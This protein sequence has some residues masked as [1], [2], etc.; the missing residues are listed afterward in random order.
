M[1]DL[2]SMNRPS[3]NP[4]L[5]VKDEPHETAQETLQRSD[6]DKIANLSPDELNALETALNAQIAQL[7]DQLRIVYYVRRADPYNPH[8][9]AG[10]GAGEN[11]GN[12]L[13]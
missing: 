6:Y 9:I 7:Q 12:V 5:V 4:D 8:R 11:R 13:D 10:R 3:Y 1:P 2:H